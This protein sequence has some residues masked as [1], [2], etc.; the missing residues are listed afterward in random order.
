MALYLKF[1]IL[2]C[3]GNGCMVVWLY[4]CVAV[5]LLQVKSFDEVKQRVHLGLY[6]KKTPDSFFDITYVDIEDDIIT[7]S[8]ELEFQEAVDTM[9]LNDSNTPIKLFDKVRT[10]K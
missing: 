8:T 7:I 9:H 6:L 5:W 3:N 2:T 10:R 4:D 1:C